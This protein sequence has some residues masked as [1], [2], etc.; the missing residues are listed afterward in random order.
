M[1]HHWARASRWACG[2]WSP[3]SSG[4]STRGASASPSAATATSPWHR[5]RT[6]GSDRPAGMSRSTSI[7]PRSSGMDAR[8]GRLAL[9]S[10][11]PASTTTTGRSC[12]GAGSPRWI[13]PTAR[14]SSGVASRTIR[15]GAVAAPPWCSRPVSCAGSVALASWTCT[16]PTAA[17][18]GAACRASQ[19]S[20]WASPTRRSWATRFC[21]ASTAAATGSTPWPPRRWP[22]DRRLRPVQL[23]A[24]VGNEAPPALAGVVNEGVDRLLEVDQLAPQHREPGGV[25]AALGRLV[26]GQL[27]AVGPDHDDR[28]PVE[29]HPGALGG[30]R[31]GLVLRESPVVGDIDRLDELVPAAVELVDRPLRPADDCVVDVG[32]A[33]QALEV[34]LLEVAAQQVGE[35]PEQARLRRPS[36]VAHDPLELGHDLCRRRKVLRRRGVA[37]AHDRSCREDS[38]DRATSEPCPSAAATR[39]YAPETT[40]PAANTPV[41]EVWSCR[42]TSIAPCRSTSSCPANSS[43]LGTRAILTTSPRT[44]SSFRSPVAWLTTTMPSSRSVPRVASTS[45]PAR[46]V[47]RRSS[48][49]WRTMS[50]RAVRAGERWSS[51]T[52]DP[53]RASA[54]ASRVPL[55]PPPTTATSR[56]AKLSSWGST[57]YVTPPSNAPSGA[58][59]RYWCLVPVATTTARPATRPPATSISPAARSTLVTG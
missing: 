59:S 28:Q 45:H 38:T 18:T 37:G 36:R 17:H 57:W 11:R 5:S 29:R 53:R 26:D 3:R 31:R 16:A 10:A 4:W 2:T 41:R 39:A 30:E 1:A 33:R 20:R 50:C 8:C 44:A 48:R 34:P 47:M 58:A 9:T 25:P 22:A 40:S 54:S 13:P 43:V 15:P 42:S 14:P 55:S 7:R 52:D 35:D 51:V 23:Q 27:G 21:S 12:A 19:P 49:T 6:A 56:P 46:S 24:L 32:A